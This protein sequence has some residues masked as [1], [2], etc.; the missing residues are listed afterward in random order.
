MTRTGHFCGTSFAKNLH[1]SDSSVTHREASRDKL[2]GARETPNRRLSMKVTLK[3]FIVGVFFLAFGTGTTLAQNGYDL[4]QQALVKE[5]AEGNLDEAILL[6]QRIAQEFAGDRALA[7]KALVQMGQ[8]YEK[9]GKAEARKVY[10]RVLR[11]YADQQ[12]QVAA[13]R[14]RLAALEEPSTPGEPS[15]LVVRQVWDR[16]ATAV[17]PDGRYL[18]FLRQDSLRVHD[19]RTGGEHVLPAGSGMISGSPVISPDGEF[20]TYVS[21]RDQKA[22]LSTARLDGSSA[23]VLVRSDE[24][25]WLEPFDWSPDAKQILAVVSRQDRT[26]QIALISVAD[27]DLPPRTSPPSKLDS[28]PFEVHSKG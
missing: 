5:R 20:V 13:A 27:G 10:E 14:T 25:P 7:A 2:Q 3:V 15:G 1:P 4:F 11:D 24:I 22:E 28:E 21:W 19:L 18:V 16:P 17:S 12:E 8:C 23:R 26:N 6:Y 9:L